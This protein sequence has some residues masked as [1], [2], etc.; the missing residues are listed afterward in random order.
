MEQGK[1]REYYKDEHGVHP[2]FG[3]VMHYV[4]AA[5]EPA[6]ENSWFNKGD[7]YAAVA[8]CKDT[9]GFIHLFGRSIGGIAD[10][11]IFTLPVDYRPGKYQEY[12]V[13]SNGTYG[14]AIDTDGTVKMV[15]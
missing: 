9:A 12:P 5:S 7:P 15:V 3:V 4:G 11:V 10:T 13:R 1:P 6:F 8:F 2:V 14:I